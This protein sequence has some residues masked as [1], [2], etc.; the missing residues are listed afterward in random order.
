MKGNRGTVSRN[1]RKRGSRKTKD[2][3]FPQNSLKYHIGITQNSF[4]T[5]N[6]PIRVTHPYTKCVT[7]TVW[8]ISSRDV[9]SSGPWKNG[10]LRVRIVSR[11][12]PADQ[13][14][15]AVVCCSSGGKKEE[16]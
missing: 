16:K 13:M 11:I 5:A 12:T 15:I 9:M 2:Q 4:S 8:S 7:P 3:H 10:Y 14:S 1:A 6:M